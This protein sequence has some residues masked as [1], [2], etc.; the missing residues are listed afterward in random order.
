[1]IGLQAVQKSNGV[2]A[3]TKPP[4]APFSSRSIQKLCSNSYGKSDVFKRFRSGVASSPVHSDDQYHYLS[5]PIPTLK[6]ISLDSED[7]LV[8][9]KTIDSSKAQGPDKI[10]AKVLLEISP[11]NLLNLSLQSGTL[12]TEWKLANIVPL[13]K[14]GSANKAE[15]YR[16]ISLLS[17]V[18]KLLESCILNKIIDHISSNLSN[19][20][21]GFL[22]QVD[23]QRL[24]YSQSIIKFKNLWT[25]AYKPTW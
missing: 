7:V 17:L 22:N 13:L 4:S 5:S 15:N 11:I 2:C 14:K 12:P 3:H 16:A 21:F 6:H 25:P 19:L 18:S 8:A 10:S 24:N 23:Q 1:M 20:Q 9:I